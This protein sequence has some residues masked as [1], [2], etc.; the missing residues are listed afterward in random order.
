MKG[1]YLCS[2]IL[3]VLGALGTPLIADNLLVNGDFEDGTVGPWV[4]D[5]WAPWQSPPPYMPGNYEVTDLSWAVYSGSKSQ[6]C[7]SSL[8]FEGGICQ[9]VTGLTPGV[10]YRASVYFGDPETPMPFGPTK[11]RVGIEP[12]GGPPLA[13]TMIWGTWSSVTS[14][15]QEASIEFTATSSIATVAFCSASDTGGGGVYQHGYPWNR[16]F[17]D[18]AVVNPQFLK[19]ANVPDFSQPPATDPMAT[20]DVGNYCGPIAAANIT[21]Y[22]DK[23][24]PAPNAQGVNAGLLKEAAPYIGYWMDTNDDGCPLRFNGSGIPGFP[25][26]KGTYSGDI[27]PGIVEFACWDANNTFGCNAPNLPN[28]K[29][30][31]PWTVVS[32]YNGVNNPNPMTLPGLWNQLVSEICAGRPMLITWSYWALGPDHHVT[33]GGIDYYE[34]GDSTGSSPDPDHTEAWNEASDST[35]GPIQIGHIV[36]AVGYYTNYDPDGVVPFPQHNLPQANWVIVHD[37]WDDTPMDIAIPCQNTA[38]FS[39][40][41]A[42]TT[43]KIVAPNNV[44]ALSEISGDQCPGDHW[45]PPLGSNVMFQLKL[46][47]TSG[48]ENAL[49]NSMR[50]IATGTGDDSVDISKVDLYEDYVPPNGLPNGKLDGADLFIASSGA[51][52]PTDNGTMF[53]IVPGPRYSIPAGSTKNILIVYQMKG[54]AV[55]PETFQF[56]IPRVYATGMNTFL[57]ATMNVGFFFTSKKKISNWWAYPPC[58]PIGLLKQQPDGTPVVYIDCS[59]II[60]AQ[61]GIFGSS[62]YVQDKSPEGACGIK[63]DF[64]TETVPTLPLGKEL[65]FEAYIDTV[66]GER[67]LVQPTIH[68]FAPGDPD[69]PEPL[70]LC[71]RSVGGGDF[72]YDSGTGAGQKGVE[73]GYGLNNVG[74]LVKTWGRVVERDTAVLAKW[75]KINDGS[76]AVVKVI[77]PA[78]VTMTLPGPLTYVMS[79]T[80][81]CGTEQDGSVL[82]PVVY[83][84]GPDDIQY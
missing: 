57:P 80:G 47:E 32:Y 20:G 39:P 29:N 41:S 28:G 14:A 66:N 72:Y 25:S 69:P 18:N 12:N 22:W 50:L 67:V 42:N 58:P 52:Y 73:G 64:G 31:Y 70:G 83:L 68:G 19:I 62:I 63:M 34:W 2:V 33:V 59:P 40:W 5:S 16:T 1:L 17:V 23:K 35:S 10:A 49:L 38:G 55:Y 75:I 45:S 6:T 74:L 30:G 44:A 61:N 71:N 21:E 43:V 65:E 60:S 77:A 46:T 4:A 9:T 76:T 11:F 79:A 24:V 27:A 13:P 54:T 26:A 56:G 37:T 51:G 36:T 48:K 3:L 8:L 81:L 78:S 84:R 15:W 53:V 7:F 82:R